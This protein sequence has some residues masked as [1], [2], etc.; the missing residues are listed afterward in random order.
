MTDEMEVELVGV[1]DADAVEDVVVLVDVPAF[2]QPWHLYP[3][4]YL[5]LLEELELEVGLG[6][7]LA[8]GWIAVD[9][10]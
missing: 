7:G 10:E 5:L 9:V 3:V 2:G 6:Q 1:I 4:L 8:A